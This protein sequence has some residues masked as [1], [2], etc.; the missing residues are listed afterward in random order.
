MTFGGDSGGPLI[1]LDGQVI[2][3]VE[4][5]SCPLA[6]FWS[7][8]KRSGN[9]MCYANIETIG[10]LMSLLRTFPLGKK[11]DRGVYV[12]DLPTYQAI[13]LKR[14]EEIFRN[15]DAKILPVHSWTQGEKTR[16]AWN[17]LTK[18][19]SG[20]VVEV[21]CNERRV[22]LG[23]VVGADGWILT[24]ASE[25]PDDPFCRLENGEIVPSRVTGIDT[26][27]DLAMLKIN[28]PRLRG[29]EWNSEATQPA[30]TFVAAPDG[31]GN[32]I[33]VGIVSVG[34]RPLEGPFPSVITRATL[35]DPTACP[36]E[37]L[38]E[39]IEGKGFRVTHV[40]G[41]AAKAG[42]CPGDLLVS[43]NDQRI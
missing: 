16:A 32:S 43:I 25:I 26:A 8:P 21:L 24:K 28:V 7:L 41:S 38:G 17:E 22:S 12:P 37:V 27:F 4:N 14:H 42:L 36:P 33:G 19:Y 18:P 13:S 23:T 9:L 35:H 30:G 10:Q 5:S 29:I 6:T 15:S 34:K 40:K 11:S 3:I 39:P 31:R 20:I 1:N 2:G